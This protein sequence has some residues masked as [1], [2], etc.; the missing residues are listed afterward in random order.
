MHF[1]VWQTQCIW[2]VCIQIGYFSFVNLSNIKFVYTHITLF[3]T[4]SHSE[5][6]ADEV[7]AEALQLA[8]VYY[9]PLFPENRTTARSISRIAPNYHPLIG[10]TCTCQMKY[11][12]LY[13]FKLLSSHHTLLQLII[14][15]R[16]LLML[17]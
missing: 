7:V 14:V 17:L 9:D 3:V 13:A 11:V 8:P 4:H 16:Q 15:L 6:V 12:N 2:F 10:L 1:V 5:V